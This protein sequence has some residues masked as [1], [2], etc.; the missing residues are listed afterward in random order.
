[1]PRLIFTKICF[2]VGESLIIENV[3]IAISCKYFLVHCIFMHL[4]IHLIRT[5][6]LQEIVKTVE[7]DIL[8]RRK[9]CLCLKMYFKIYA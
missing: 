5:R 8:A 9:I 3:S 6:R 2:I 7:I 1:M 4:G